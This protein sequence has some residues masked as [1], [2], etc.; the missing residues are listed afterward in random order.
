M[1]ADP[2]DIAT[3]FFNH[4]TANRIDDALAML[5]DDVLY[6]NVPFP[7]IVGRDSVRKFHQDFG[8]GTAF[9]V[10]WKVINIAAA[11]KVVLN[12]RIDIFTHAGGR[13]I[14]LPVMGTLTVEGGVI[15]VWRDYFDPADFNRQLGL[16][17][18]D[19]DATVKKG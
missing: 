3:T 10:D 7:D 9:T 15:T 17:L 18:K 2:I 14:T 11:G 12:E 8:V 16:I 19:A 13:T 5:S 1:S 4:W 6:D